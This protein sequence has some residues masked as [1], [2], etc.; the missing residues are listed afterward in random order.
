VTPVAPHLREALRGFC[1]AAFARLGYGADRDEIPYVLDEHG[2]LYEYRPLVRDHVESRIAELSRLE[3][4]RIA[5]VELGREPAASIF[6]RE[7]A[8]ERSAERTLLAAILVPLLVSVAEACGGFDW[9]DAA[10]ERAYAGLEGSLFGADR[11]YAATAPLVGLSAGGT[12]ELARGI[13]V[14][15]IADAPPEQ[16]CHLAFERVL[17]AGGPVLPDAPGELA[18]AVTALRLA[19]GAAL[20]AGPVVLEQLDGHPLG[21]RPLLGIAATEPAGE[22][23]R[24][25][26]WRGKLAGDLLARL[27]ESEQDSELGD[28]L[29]RWELSLFESEPLRSE[30]LREALA[31][32]LGGADGL[33]AAA[34]RATT[35]IGEIAEPAARARV[36]GLLELARGGGAGEEVPDTVRRIFVESLLADDRPRLL[37]RLDEAL[38][39]LAPR[40]AGFFS[41]RASAA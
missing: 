7:A 18:D 26:P 10:F 15:R 6:A 34:M 28:A 36:E 3:D 32:L 8:D 16:S 19:T 5:L 13:R 1:L 31:A 40:P 41:A 35:L 17:P 38:L 21:P 24:L 14:E 33:W 9:D 39:G 23:T 4:A 25:D 37:A 11:R 12:I 2:G 29:E 22:P 20:S 30:R 27:P